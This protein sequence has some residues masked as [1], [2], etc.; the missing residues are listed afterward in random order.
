MSRTVVVDWWTGGLTEATEIDHRT[1]NAERAS[2][3]IL[4]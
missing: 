1:A 4:Y 2:D 3:V